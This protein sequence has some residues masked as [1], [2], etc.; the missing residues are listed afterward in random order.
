MLDLNFPLA[1]NIYLSKEQLHII[2]FALHKAKDIEENTK[3]VYEL[4]CIEEY[5]ERNL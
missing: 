3:I 5:I 1:N 2:L 4:I